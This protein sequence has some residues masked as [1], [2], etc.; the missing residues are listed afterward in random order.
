MLGHTLPCHLLPQ[1]LA[2]GTVRAGAG[3]WGRHRGVGRPQSRKGSICRRGRLCGCRPGT[4]SSLCPQ[5]C[6][7]LGRSRACGHGCVGTATVHFWTPTAVFLM[8]HP[9]SFLPPSSPCS[10]HSCSAA[11]LPPVPCAETPPTGELALW[12]LYSNV[13]SQRDPQPTQAEPLPPASSPG[14]TSTSSSS[15]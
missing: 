15:P 4:R 9:R 14:D 12:G 6:L 2:Q 11:P 5:G 8:L 13:S 10:P 1:T 7:S 3:T